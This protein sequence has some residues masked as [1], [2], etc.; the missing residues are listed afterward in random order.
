MVRECQHHA[1]QP[2]S[3]AN[4]IALDLLIVPVQWSGVRNHLRLGASSRCTAENQ[5][6]S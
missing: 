3:Y 1:P 5:Q 6:L 4:T 2:T